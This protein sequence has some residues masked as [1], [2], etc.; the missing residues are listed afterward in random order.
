[1]TMR[2]PLHE[3]YRRLSLLRRPGYNAW[4]R[5]ETIVI[6]HAVQ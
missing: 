6:G 5:Y 2:V 1:M 3:K 4:A